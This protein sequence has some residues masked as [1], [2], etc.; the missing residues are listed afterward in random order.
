MKQMTVVP[1]MALFT[2]ASLF[3]GWLSTSPL[4]LFAATQEEGEKHGSETP[5]VDQGQSAEEDYVQVKGN[6]VEI[7]FKEHKLTPNKIMV[8]PGKITF[9]LHN[10]GR[11]AHDFRIVGPEVDKRV[12]RFRP[13]KSARMEVT[14]AEG[15]YEMSCKVS[16]HYKKGMHG[17]LLVTPDF[18]V[19]AGGG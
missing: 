7:E 14:L 10:K 8:R 16:N 1:A 2:F 6:T 4:P 17:K 3:F 12:P 13:G 5:M 15:E 18:N 11:Y 19:A 9:K